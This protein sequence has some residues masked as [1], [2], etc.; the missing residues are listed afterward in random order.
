M[1][2]KALSLGDGSSQAKEKLFLVFDDED[3]KIKAEEI[4]ILHREEEDGT[5]PDV[6]ELV[7]A[8]N[9][10]YRRVDGFAESRLFLVRGSVLLDVRIHEGEETPLVFRAIDLGKF[11]P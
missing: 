1:L 11:V 5:L 8:I 7:G 6:V 3:S 9:Q 10:G 4:E 2:C